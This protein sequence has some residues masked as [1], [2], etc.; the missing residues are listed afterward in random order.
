[1][2]QPI[3]LDFQAT[4]PLCDAARA[5]MTPWLGEGFGNPHSEHRLGWAA[6][7][8]VE[9]ARGE[10]AALIGAQPGEIVFTSGATE[11]SNTALKG[12][13][14]APGQTRRRIVTVATEHSCVLETARWLESLGAPLTVLPVGADGLVDMDA[15]ADAMGED[16]A[17]VAVMAVNNEI[18]VIQPVAEIAALAKACGALVYCDVAQAAGKIPLDVAALGVDLMGLSAHKLYGPKGIGALW[19]RPGVRLTPLLHG[20]GQEGEGLRSGT[21]APALCA[22]FGAAA[23]EARA[24]LAEDA[25]H[26]DALW[27]RALAGLAAVEHR[28]NGSTVKRWRGNLNVSFPGVDGARLLADVLRTVALSSGSACAAAKGRPS[29]VLAALG[30]A[31]AFAKA[32]LRI[33]WGRGTTA[34]EIDAAMA[35]IVAAVRAQGV[36]AA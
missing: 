2:A 1:M 12:V 27:A 16:V 17:L 35:A 21:L 25:A 20:G 9:A 11:A 8:A 33:G 34:D 10:I 29:H 19:V 13:L 6:Y 26:V 23:R 3:Y 36:K 31:P 28:I 22:G 7:A 15:V 32:T 4:T 18:G 5:A 14:T 24:R 30:A